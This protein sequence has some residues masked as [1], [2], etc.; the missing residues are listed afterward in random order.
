MI[1]LV[2]PVIALCL[3]HWMN[4]EA[5]QLKTLTGALCI[6]VALWLHEVIADEKPESS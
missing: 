1:A 5:V 2:S 3:G 4:Q 6:L